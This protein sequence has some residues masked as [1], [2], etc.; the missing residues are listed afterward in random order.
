MS[1]PVCARSCGGGT[2]VQR[3]P[4]TDSICPV[5]WEEE[6]DGG[7]PD[8]NHSRLNPQLVCVFWPKS[9]QKPPGVTESTKRPRLGEC[10]PRGVEARVPQPR[11]RYF[12]EKERRGGGHFLHRHFVITRSRKQS[13]E[14][15]AARR[16]IKTLSPGNTLASEPPFVPPTAAICC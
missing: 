15:H 8:A 1:A 3:Q 14:S 16:D 12:Q 9:R 5:C 2:V 13:K 4:R 6:D 11:A 7:H 10:F